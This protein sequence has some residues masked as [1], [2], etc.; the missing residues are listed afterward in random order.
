MHRL[1][2]GLVLGAVAFLSTATWA[3][4]ETTA[5]EAAPAAESPVAESPV[6]E[7]PVAESPVAAPPPSAPPPRPR[8]LSFFPSPW[9][10]RASYVVQPNVTD[11]K[12]AYD[13]VQET[14]NTARLPVLMQQQVAV[15][16]GANYGM[17]QLHARDEGADVF[18]HNLAAPVSVIWATDDFIVYGEASAGL[19]TD[20]AGLELQDVQLLAQ[21]LFGWVVNDELLL[22]AGAL[23]YPAFGD[24]AALPVL[25]LVWKPAPLFELNILLPSYAAVFLRP[26]ESLRFRLGLDVDPARARLRTALA[27]DK[28]GLNTSALFL[29]LGLTTEYA[30]IP[31][32][33]L[34]L[35]GGAAADGLVLVS[36]PGGERAPFQ[37]VPAAFAMAGVELTSELFRRRR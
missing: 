11:E 22:E 17:Y 33:N 35:T 19:Y 10:L 27:G 14:K 12:P 31:G 2:H 21:G 3:E 32:V 9:L 25:G 7:P 13:L 37:V 1:F 30:V 4:G 5:A 24:F 18:I 36:L 8:S 23:T 15:F 28:Q 20:F 29:R 26:T 16:V 6:A 34:Q